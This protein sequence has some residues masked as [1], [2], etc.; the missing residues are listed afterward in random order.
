MF[1][2]AHSKQHRAPGVLW[3]C[4]RCTPTHPRLRAPSYR[5]TPHAAAAQSEVP[6]A[7]TH[8]VLQ[9]KFDSIEDG[10]AAVARGEF[11]LVL[12]DQNRENEGD[13]II[14]ADKATPAQI[15]YMVEYTTGA[16]RTDSQSENP[17][18]LER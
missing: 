4:K 13:L 12:D 10:I 18:L 11:V 9:E 3:C 16:I 15:A 7:L 6:D 1:P 5:T 8:S 17:A 14:A 2:G